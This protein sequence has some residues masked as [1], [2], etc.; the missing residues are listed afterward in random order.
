V[1]SGSALQ[2]FNALQRLVAYPDT[3]RSHRSAPGKPLAGRL[4]LPLLTGVGGGVVF[5]FG[6]NSTAPALPNDPILLNAFRAIYTFA[7]YFLFLHELAHV[8]SGHVERSAEI[9]RESHTMK[10]AERPLFIEAHRFPLEFLADSYSV[11]MSTGLIET[12]VQGQRDPADRLVQSDILNHLVYWG[13][14]V[15]FVFLLFEA[16]SFA[17]HE[18]TYPSAADRA[19]F[20]RTY[21]LDRAGVPII[22]SKNIS[23]ENKFA[24]ISQGY[25]EAMSAWEALGWQR[26]Q[27]LPKSNQTALAARANE[28]AA[29]CKRPPC[30]LILRSR[31]TA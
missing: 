3:L 8:Y 27:G 2:L 14:A 22:G 13:F 7:H 30:M 18:E 20:S 17:G 6:P 25:D 24:A 9:V 16:R 5:K 1:N 23:A 11:L 28:E 31:R 26:Q 19:F 15:A 4:G 29:R 12:V 21:S 10:P